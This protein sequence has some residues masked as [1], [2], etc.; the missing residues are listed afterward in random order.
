[1]S[2][3]QGI[4][5]AVTLAI[6]EKDLNWKNKKTAALEQMEPPWWDTMVG[7]LGS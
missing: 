5:E 4:T 6:N 2:K 1:M 3:W 7:S